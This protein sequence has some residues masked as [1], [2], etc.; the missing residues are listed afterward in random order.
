LLYQRLVPEI[1]EPFQNR[2]FS[3]SY[4]KALMA[5]NYKNKPFAQNV[6]ASSN[7]FFSNNSP[8]PIPR[9]RVLGF[10]DIRPNFSTS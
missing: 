5:E 2:A 3:I 10:I 9:P 8:I 7:T 1:Q 4:A 6:L